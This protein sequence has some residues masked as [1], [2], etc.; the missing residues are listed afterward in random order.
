MIWDIQIFVSKETC[1]CQRERYRARRERGTEKQRLARLAMRREYDRRRYTAVIMTIEQC[2]RKCRQ[3]RRTTIC[4]NTLSILSVFDDQLQIT[5]A[6][7]PMFNICLVL[8]MVTTEQRAEQYLEKY[9]ILCCKLFVAWLI[10]PI[11]G[12]SVILRGMV[13]RAHI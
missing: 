13:D 10:V 8:Y 9:S 6:R 11:F 3:E 7:P 2:Q 12:G 5:Q 4:E 1:R